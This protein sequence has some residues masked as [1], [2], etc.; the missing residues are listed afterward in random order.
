M[1]LNVNRNNSEYNNN[2]ICYLIMLIITINIILIV[3]IN[4]VDITIHTIYI[5]NYYPI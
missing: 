5:I 3:S 1:F 4:N 2:M